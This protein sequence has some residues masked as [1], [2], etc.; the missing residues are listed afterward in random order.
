M[1]ITF[2]SHFPGRGGSNVMLQQIE[3][4][5]HSRGHET[6]ILV[7][8]DSP[9]PMLPKYAVATP[10]PAGS[11]DWKARVRGLQMATERTRPDL[12]YSISGLNE[13]NVLRYLRC[14]RVRHVF[15]LEQH[16]YIDMLYCLAQVDG[17]AEAITANTPDVLEQIRSVC[18]MPTRMV[19]APYRF[20]RAYVDVPDLR[21]ESNGPRDRPVEVCFVGRLETYQKQVHWLPEIIRLCQQHGRDLRWHI[22]GDGPAEAAM[23]QE[24]AQS[25]CATLVSFHGWRGPADLA[26]RLPGHDVFFLCSRWEGLPLSLVEAMLCGLAC[27]VP[28]IP[29]GITFALARGGGWT[30]EAVS[31]QAG[32]QALLAATADPTTLRQ[33]RVAA[34]R[35]ARAAFIGEVVEKQLEQLDHELRQLV[36]NQRFLQI[37]RPRKLRWAPL[38]QVFRRKCR[39]ALP[40]CR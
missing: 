22:Y 31:P 35:L 36:F 20:G 15:S 18:R 38:W 28:A 39:R 13:L 16:D 3:E 24:L 14:P 9:D 6:T 7:G 34:Q 23:H 4:Y 37:H 17:F 19:V 10:D 21:P 25:G 11:Q 27:V 5:L 32:A 1:R 8:E 30:Y 12:V 2:L 40:K 29:A 26:K 33:Q